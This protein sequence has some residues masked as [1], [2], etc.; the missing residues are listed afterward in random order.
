MTVTLLSL[1]TNE[2]T[3]NG[4]LPLT[5]S[6]LANQYV[7]I[8]S[9]NFSLYCIIPLSIGTVS[10]MKTSA[11]CVILGYNSDTTNN[12][13]KCLILKFRSALRRLHI[14]KME[15]YKSHRMQL[16]AIHITMVAATLKIRFT[17]LKWFSKTLIFIIMLL[18]VSV[19]VCVCG[20]CECIADAICQEAQKMNCM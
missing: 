4:T 13:I 15:I 3:F 2:R 19:C 5:D 18:S 12:W 11:M 7:I 6:H 16:N 17:L 10:Q 1:P 20:C 9:L 8:F 14:S